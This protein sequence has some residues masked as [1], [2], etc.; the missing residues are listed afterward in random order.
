MA[1]TQ[2]DYR[3]I[4][5]MEKRLASLIDRLPPR[6]LN[7]QQSITPI[8]HRWPYVVYK[9]SSVI[10]STEVFFRA[11][12]D[13][14]VVAGSEVDAGTEAIE[15][16][17]GSGNYDRWDF[18]G[19]GVRRVT[20]FAA[21]DLLASRGVSGTSYAEFFRRWAFKHDL[22]L[23][24]SPLASRPIGRNRHSEMVTFDGITGDFPFTGA[25]FDSSQAHVC[26]QWLVANSEATD[27]RKVGFTLVTTN[28]CH[29]FTLD[30]NG[31]F[32]ASLSPMSVNALQSSPDPLLLIERLDTESLR[33]TSRK[34][35][36]ES[37]APPP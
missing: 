20:L 21:F 16:S 2:R 7:A 33:T 14:P 3:R 37:G 19:R 11:S 15:S 22:L 5:A 4:E 12:G 26:P 36:M 27:G 30:G 1:F 17:I 9:L 32:D 23:T 6:R 13:N 35:E 24:S 18:W 34:I 10:V 28:Q 8:G 31:A 29:R 25:I